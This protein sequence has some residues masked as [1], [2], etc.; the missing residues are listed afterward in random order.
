MNLQSERF[1]SR[2]LSGSKRR[3][4]RAPAS[5]ALALCMAAAG[6]YG[7]EQAYV[8]GSRPGEAFFDREVLP[9]LVE[10]NC[11]MCH[12]VG[13]VQPNVMKYVD[14]LPYLAMGD[15]PETNPVI[16]KL[17]NLRAIRP[18]LP[19]HPGGPRCE[20]V[21]SEP[22]ASILRWREVEFGKGSGD[23]GAQP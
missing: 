16:R 2:E 19:T 23:G 6:T 1:W 14:L 9:R 18:D 12:A 15:E 8:A 17:A 20:T 5:A 3:A 10:N 22:C 4:C 13:Y 7:A 11:Q 21:Q